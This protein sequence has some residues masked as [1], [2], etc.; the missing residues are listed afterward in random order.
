MI[1][2]KEPGENCA[3]VAE[4]RQSAAQALQRI[5]RQVALLQKKLEQIS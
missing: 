2:K 3:R 1:K 5:C 4:T